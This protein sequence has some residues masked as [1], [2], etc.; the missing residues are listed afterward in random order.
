M[1][2]VKNV[3]GRQ[4]RHRALQPAGIDWVI[5]IGSKVL[6]LT[7]S[8]CHTCEALSYLRSLVIPAKPVL[9]EVEGAGIQYSTV[10]NPFLA[11]ED[12]IP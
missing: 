5:G 9:S 2:H 6:K 4:R 3:F 10:H 7:A 12:M 8:P 11:P 1:F